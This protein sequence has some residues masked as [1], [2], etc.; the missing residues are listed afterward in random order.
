MI[1]RNEDGHSYDD[2]HF[3]HPATWKRLGEVVSGT[4]RWPIYR[5]RDEG[6]VRVFVVRR[7]EARG[8]AAA[9]KFQAARTAFVSFLAGLDGTEPGTYVLWG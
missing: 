5:R 3:T 1:V 7:D 2:L 8:P 4:M 9:R 6:G